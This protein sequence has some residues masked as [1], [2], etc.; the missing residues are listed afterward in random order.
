MPPMLTKPPTASQN[1][2]GKTLD[3]NVLLFEQHPG[4][5][6]GLLAM[7]LA[8]FRVRQGLS[9][10]DLTGMRIWCLATMAGTATL[11]MP[12]PVM[13]DRQPCKAQHKLFHGRPSKTACLQGILVHRIP[14]MG[15]LFRGARRS[16]VLQDRSDSLQS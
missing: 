11:A 6:L 7:I 16:L 13:T 4:P 1:P 10:S 15:L 8:T 3:A 12:E 14:F 9:G 5:A 2:R